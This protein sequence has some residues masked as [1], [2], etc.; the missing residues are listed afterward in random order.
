MNGRRTLE[1]IRG[2]EGLLQDT[3]YLRNRS[4]S[5]E[6]KQGAFEW[7]SARVIVKPFEGLLSQTDPDEFRWD[8][9]VS[10]FT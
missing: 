6:Q 1:N 4:R 5:V 9:I 10:G 3:S 2:L 8:Q 7:Q